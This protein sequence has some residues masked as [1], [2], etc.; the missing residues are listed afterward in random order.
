MNGTWGGIRFW[1]IVISSSLVG[2][3]GWCAIDYA[4][5]QYSPDRMH[6]FEWTA[7]IFPLAVLALGIFAFRK[8][9]GQAEFGGRL[10]QPCWCASLQ[11]H[12]LYSLGFHSIYQSVVN[13]ESLAPAYQVAAVAPPV[14][15]AIWRFSFRAGIPA[16]DPAH[17]M[18]GN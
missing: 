10:S 14:Q 2:F 13:S 11:W 16:L 6:D 15:Q 4:L 1:T 3:C 8:P 9:R 17:L 18:A 5:V 12:W 7:L